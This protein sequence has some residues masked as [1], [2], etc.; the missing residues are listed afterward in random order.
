MGNVHVVADV[1]MATYGGIAIACSS[2]G[3]ATR[4][5]KILWLLGILGNGAFLMYPA[6]KV[7]THPL[8]VLGFSARGRYLGELLECWYHGRTA[9]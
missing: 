7:P 6:G 3:L 1:L 2:I 8:R 9:W 4:L 5:A